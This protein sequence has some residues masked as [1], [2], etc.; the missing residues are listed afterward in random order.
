MA[1]TP[2]QLALLKVDIGVMYP[3]ADQIVF[4]G[5]LLTTAAAQILR[6]G[7]VLV[8]D[9]LEDDTLIAMYGRLALP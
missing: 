5:A 6:K 7:I 1:Y 8:V 9:D 2:I 4:F 3:T